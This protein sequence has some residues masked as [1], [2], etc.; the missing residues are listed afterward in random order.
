MEQDIK[1]FLDAYDGAVMLKADLMNKAKDVQQHGIRVDT[2]MIER[3]VNHLDGVIAG[4]EQ[5]RQ[6]A[7]EFAARVPKQEPPPGEEHNRE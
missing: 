5:I 1:Q 7:D 4:L 6:H 2:P 3:W